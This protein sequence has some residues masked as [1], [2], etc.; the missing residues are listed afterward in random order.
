MKRQNILLVKTTLEKGGSLCPLS[1]LRTL[2]EVTIT[3]VSR[4]HTSPGFFFVFTH[5]PILNLS[6]SSY[7][8]YAVLHLVFFH[9][10]AGLNDLSAKAHTNLVRHCTFLHFEKLINK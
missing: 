9:S 3:I 6:P 4:M 1:D 2:P 7:T 5:L 8:I 10:M